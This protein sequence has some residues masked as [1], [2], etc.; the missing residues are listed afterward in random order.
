M[1]KL[2]LS[3][4]TGYY[5]RVA[6]IL[7][8]RVQI[9]GCTVVSVMP[10]RPGEIFHRA[11]NFR[12]FDITE[13]SLSS[14]CVLTARGESPYIA[15]PIFVSRVFRHSCIYIRTDRG[16]TRP[17]DL[18]GRTIGVPEYQQTAG[19][20]IRGILQDEHGVR[21]TDV[22]WRNGGIE[23]PG[24]K[25]RTTLQLPP[26]IDLQP[27]P[28]DRTLSDMLEHGEIDAII[29][30]RTPPCAR[31]LG[32]PVARL[33]PDYARA[34]EAYFQRTGFFPIMH[35]IAIR[36]DLAETHPWRPVEVY[37]AFV[38]AKE[39]AIEG[40]EDVGALAATL[41]WGAY[42]LDRTR[43]IMGKDYWP[44]GFDE[45]RRELETFVRYL[46]EQGLAARR[47]A[48]EEMFAPSTLE[49]A[50]S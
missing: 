21:I 49:L 50:K 33:F 5:D 42:E 14:Y 22:K 20:W 16:I 36:R 37:K 48:V 1:S 38:T 28:S 26:E 6:P 7:D 32:R 31:R 40:L 43:A 35:V 2:R 24:R 9:T 11:L 4:G 27:I 25:E 44:Y 10:L 13:L 45:N 3:I 34:E 39:V 29:A 47:L 41:P 46:Q 23:E 30:P 18:K 12:E 8:G 17:E 19:V 15:I